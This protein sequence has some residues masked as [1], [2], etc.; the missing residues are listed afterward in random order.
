MPAAASL[1][2]PELRVV[3]FRLRQLEEKILAKR[4][5]LGGSNCRIQGC[6]VQFIAQVLLV[7]RMS[8]AIGRAPLLVYK[9]DRLHK[10]PASSANRE[11]ST[12]L[13][14]FT[15]Q[16][17]AHRQTTPTPAHDPSTKTM[18]YIE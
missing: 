4:V 5:T 1:F 11:V 13:P 17:I 14:W 15:I 8:S 7:A 10:Y 18:D 9:T 12:A 6:S 3:R 16:R 2:A